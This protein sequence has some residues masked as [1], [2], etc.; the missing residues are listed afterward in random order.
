MLR[1]LNE[2]GEGRPGRRRHRAA[3]VRRLD[4]RPR[5]GV[6]GQAAHQPGTVLP[7]DAVV[8]RGTGRYHTA[9]RK[10]TPA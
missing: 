4:H 6:L 5:L 10:D 2:S 8:T 7:N 1:Q 9:K 3:R